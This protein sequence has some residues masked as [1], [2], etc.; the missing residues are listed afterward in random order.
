LAPLRLLVLGLFFHKRINNGATQKMG[1]LGRAAAT[2]ACAF[3]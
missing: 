1:V 2:N 3:S